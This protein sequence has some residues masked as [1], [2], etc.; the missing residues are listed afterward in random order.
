MD[1]ELLE[2][3][4]SLKFLLPDPVGAFLPSIWIRDTHFAVLFTFIIW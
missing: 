3:L 4:W 2:L 1:Y